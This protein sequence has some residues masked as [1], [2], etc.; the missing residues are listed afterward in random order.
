MQ[1]GRNRS[2]QR[3]LAK[4]KADVNTKTGAIIKI[5]VFHHR[6]AYSE[7]SSTAVWIV[8]GANLQYATCSRCRCICTYAVAL[9]G[10]A[11]LLH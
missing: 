4:K 2:C 11:W 1:L 10:W 6:H 3:P 9:P 8:H 7:S 5:V